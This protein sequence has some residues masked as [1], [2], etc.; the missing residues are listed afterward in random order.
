MEIVY[1]DE[2]KLL[3]YIG[4]LCGHRLELYAPPQGGAQGQNSPGTPKMGPKMSQFAVSFGLSQRGA[5][6]FLSRV[7]SGHPV[8]VTERRAVGELWQSTI[9]PPTDS[10]S[11]SLV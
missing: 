6:A 5:L 9:R 8:I 7:T 3:S 1:L 2:P 4:T 11:G 10:M